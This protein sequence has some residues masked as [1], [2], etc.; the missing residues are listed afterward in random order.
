[1]ANT[2]RRLFL[3]GSLYCKVFLPP[4]FMHGLNCNTPPR[5]KESCARV[6]DARGIKV[7]IFSFRELTP[8]PNP[9][10]EQDFYRRVT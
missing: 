9:S 8:R 7:G 4:L 6:S 3:K 1:M 5:A 10:P 2:T